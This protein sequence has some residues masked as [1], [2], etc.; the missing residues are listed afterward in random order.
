MNGKPAGHPLRAGVG[1]W[2]QGLALVKA[3]AGGER[4]W[5]ERTGGERVRDGRVEKG[6][7]EQAGGDERRSEGSRDGCGWDS[8]GLGFREDTRS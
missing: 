8:F 1:R 6:G 2:R 7:K 5:D 3:V 4:A